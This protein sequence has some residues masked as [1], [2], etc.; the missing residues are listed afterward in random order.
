MQQNSPFQA[1][2]GFQS[3]GGI[4]GMQGGGGIG[5]YAQGSAP[6]GNNNNGDNEPEIQAFSL[7]HEPSP[8]MGDRQTFQVMPE[9]GTPTQDRNQRAL[10]FKHANEVA[11]AH[12]YGVTFDNG[13]KAEIAPTDHA[14]M[15]R[16]TFTGTDNSLVFDNVNSDYGLTLA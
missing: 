15:F 1:G 9:Q 2:G 6:F 4:G 10:A 7:S 14:A 5:G 16:F 12:Y 3:G 11:K 8:W 13:M